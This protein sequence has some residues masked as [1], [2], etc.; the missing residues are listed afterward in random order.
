MKDPPDTELSLAEYSDVFILNNFSGSWLKRRSLETV[1]FC[2]N[3][4]SGLLFWSV[5]LSRSVV[6]IVSATEKS[7]TPSGSGGGETIS[8]Y[9]GVN[10]ST[11]DIRKNANKVFLSILFQ[12][13]FAAFKKRITSK[14]SNDYE[15]GCHKQGLLF[16]SLNCIIGASWVKPAGGTNKWRNCELIPSNKNKKYTLYYLPR[17]AF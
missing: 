1:V 15:I 11:R 12:R 5:K 7:S 3:L 2:S 14:Q 17:K 6:L 4:G 16:N 8:I 9:L 10:T 13:I